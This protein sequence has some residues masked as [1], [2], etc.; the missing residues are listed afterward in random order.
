MDSINKNNENPP[1]DK[2]PARLQITDAIM[3]TGFSTVSGDYSFYLSSITEQE[4]GSGNNQFM[5]LELRNANEVAASSTFNN[6]WNSTYSTLN[7]LKQII[8]KVTNE[9]GS[10]FGQYDLLGMAQILTALNYGVLTDMHGDI[11]CSE[12]LQGLNNLQPKLDK[13]EDVYNYIFN[14][15]DEGIANLTNGKSLSSAGS[16]D[17]LYGN[18]NSSW[19]AAAYA[20]KARY[21]LHTMVQNPQVLSQVEEACNKAIENGF[22]GMNVTSFNGSTTDN[23]WSAFIWSRYYVGSSSTVTKIMESTSDPRIE[24]YAPESNIGSDDEP[25]YVRFAYD[26]GDSDAAKESAMYDYPLWYDNGA[27]DIHLMSKSELYFILAEVQVRQGKD[28]SAAF[29]AAIKANFDEL[30]EISN[31]LELGYTMDADAF[32]S[33]LGGATLNNIMVQKYISQIR[34]EQVETYNDIRRCQA[35]G[36]SY[37]TLSNPYNSQSGINRWPH[38]LPYGNSS[39]ISN[40]NTRTAYGDGSYVYSEKIWL[41]GGTR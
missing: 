4:F 20:L 18:N 30:N 38:R 6:S 22:N 9:N 3:S 13:Q 12:A 35:L 34:D 37:I 27:N 23:P 36:E 25:E 17:I 11:P 33:Q 32:I 26:P 24:L 10:D 19:I 1:S 40:Q 7:N 41:Y 31:E 29:S 5:N 8:D 39:V 15:L 2:V 28:A 16:Q 14:M 21:L